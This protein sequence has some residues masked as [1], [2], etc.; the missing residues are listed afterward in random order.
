MKAE[1]R[2]Q[3]NYLVI[4]N[5]VFYPDE[6][7]RGNPYN[8]TFDVFVESDSGCFRGR[9]ECEY[10]IKRFRQFVA[11]LQEMYDLKRTSV[12]F[13]DICY[14]SKI[15]FTMNKLGSIEII[16]SVYADGMQHSL[17]FSFYTDQSVFLPFINELHKLIEA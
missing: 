15:T 16:G 12:V 3:G 13:E 5:F 4:D 17:T 1:C 9:G 14:G 2:D 6:L 7:R 8:T 10:D 11:E